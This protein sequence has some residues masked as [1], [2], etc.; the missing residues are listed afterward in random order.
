MRRY[1]V[2]IVAAVLL[3]AIALAA[4]VTVNY[5]NPNPPPAALEVSN[6]NPLPV[7]PNSYPAG[8]TPLVGVGTGSTGAVT[9][10]LTGAAG[11]TTYLC[12]FDVSAIGGTAAVGPITATPL[13]GS[14][15]LSLTYQFSSSAAGSTLNRGYSPCI[16]APAV[17]TSI[18]VTT[19]ADGTASAVDVNVWGYRK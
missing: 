1:L 15:P 19:T 16:P 12:G 8:A 2:T 14:S 9:G 17:N 18:T 10:T 13:A 3:P 7:A 6:N 4:D 5:V 11:V